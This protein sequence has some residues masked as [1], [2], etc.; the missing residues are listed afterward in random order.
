MPMGNVNTTVLMLPYELC[1]LSAVSLVAPSVLLLQW[2]FFFVSLP[3]LFPV[4]NVSIQL[5]SMFIQLYIGLHDKPYEENDQDDN[6][7]KG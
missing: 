3:N 1:I 2:N 7:N 5:Y 4:K 6:L